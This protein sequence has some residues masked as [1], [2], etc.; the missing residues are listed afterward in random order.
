MTVCV[1]AC[2]RACEPTVHAGRSRWSTL[3]QQPVRVERVDVQ[4]VD[5][6][7]NREGNIPHGTYNMQTRSGRALAYPLPSLQGPL[8]RL[9]GQGRDLND[10]GPGFL[11]GGQ[12][13][14]VTIRVSP[15]LPK[16]MF[17][18]DTP[19]LHNNTLQHSTV[20]HVA[21][22][23]V[24]VAYTAC[25]HQPRPL[26]TATVLFAPYIRASCPP[27]DAKSGGVCARSV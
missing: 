27:R 10:R 7:C 11:S 3:A 9:H 22:G 19:Q 23:D 17:Q 2:V 20:Q 12:P 18:L 13:S 25:A 5:T 15:A 6:A 8:R 1:R 24:A 16:V 21:A 4:Q 26:H 14:S